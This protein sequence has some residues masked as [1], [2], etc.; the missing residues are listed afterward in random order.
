[1]GQWQHIRAITS[2]VTN[3]F[4][5]RR[6]SGCLQII[7][8]GILPDGDHQCDI[9]K[10]CQQRLMPGLCTLPAG[11]QVPAFTGAR[12]TEPHGNQRYLVWTVK[13]FRVYAHPLP[14][15]I[16]TGIIKRDPGIVDP[17]SRSLAGDQDSSLGIGLKNRVCTE[18]QRRFTQTAFP[19]FFR[20]DIKLCRQDSGAQD[21]RN[22][23]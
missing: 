21:L 14:Q 5:E 20:Q 4:S 2:P 18:R 3:G 23:I 12:I 22:I 9:W 19:D 11:R 6:F 10:C 15:P 16:S 17:D 13:N 8:M 1:M 7:T